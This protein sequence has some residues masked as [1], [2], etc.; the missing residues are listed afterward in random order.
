MK[1]LATAILAKF[2]LHVERL[3]K[4]PKETLLGLSG[5]NVRNVLDI[6]ANTGQFARVALD[7]FPRARIWCFEPLPA[8]Y[9]LLKG[10]ER[11]SDGRVTALNFALG[12][13]Q[14]VMNLNYHNEHSSS[15][16]LMPTTAK[17]EELFS[18]TRAQ[19]GV[20]VEVRRLDDVFPD[21]VTPPFEDL[22]I[23]LDVQGYEAEVI[24]GGK[25]TVGLAKA[26]IVEVCFDELYVGAPSFEDLV[27]L[28]GETGHRF[29]GVIEQFPAEDGHVIFVDALFKKAE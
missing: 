14:G 18:Q 17:C 6:G 23:K 19:T 4:H 27:K 15:S 16:S 8:A 12:A 10:I 24:A 5:E 26:V 28:L 2:D 25:N 29:A 11:R 7:R 3:S 9:E 13:K 1:Y 21:F 20:P 22:V